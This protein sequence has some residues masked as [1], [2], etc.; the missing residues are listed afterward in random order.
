VIG[1]GESPSD[2]LDDQLKSWM[3]HYEQVSVGHRRRGDD[4]RVRWAQDKLWVDRLEATIEAHTMAAA[5]VG[6][7][8]HP[9]HVGAHGVAV[10]G[11]AVDEAGAA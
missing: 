1:V 7:P 4:R 2:A 3:Y 9:G 8:A 11:Q 5:Q 6:R 10:P